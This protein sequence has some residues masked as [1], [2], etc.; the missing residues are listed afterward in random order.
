MFYDSFDFK[1][2]ICFDLQ[3]LSIYDLMS[4]IIGLY[5]KSVDYQIF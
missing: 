5:A 4:T 2:Y 1:P 3:I